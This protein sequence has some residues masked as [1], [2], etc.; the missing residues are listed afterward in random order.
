ML[1]L[2]SR[3]ISDKNSMSIKSQQQT[4]NMQKSRQL[5]IVTGTWLKIID[6]SNALLILNCVNLYINQVIR[7]ET[8]TF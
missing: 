4:P 3:K 5:T 6:A 1:S 8:L 2:M 7:I